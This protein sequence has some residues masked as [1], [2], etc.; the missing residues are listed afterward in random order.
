V[1]DEADRLFESSLAAVVEQ[2]LLACEP[3][4]ASVRIVGKKRGSGNAG[5]A[6]R[7]C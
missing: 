4:H 3:E 5:K 7:L 1:L 6:L 2:V